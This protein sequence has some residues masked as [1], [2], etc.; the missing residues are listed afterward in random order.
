MSGEIDAPCVRLELI[1]RPEAAR[2]VRSMSSAAGDALG[3]DPELQGDV[4]TAVAE[5]CNNVILHAY[6][7]TPGPLAVT[8]EAR[9]D[10]LEV[11]I[12]DH[13]YGMR[14]AIPELDRLKVGLALMSA[15]AD[16]A[17]FISPPEGGTEVRLAFANRS[18]LRPL[19]APDRVPV[20]HED[21]PDDPADP[22]PP[23]LTGPFVTVPGDVVLT[24]SPV[25]LLGPILGRVGR[26]LAPSAGFSL[27][28]CYDVY[29]LTDALAAH[30]AR[31]AR[32]EAISVALGTREQRLEFALAPLRVGTGG[33][34]EAAASGAPV[35][36][37]SLLTEEIAISAVDNYETLHVSMRDRRRG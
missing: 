34:L 4:N 21:D 8:L 30:A 17:E 18:E 31:A 29:L 33:C 23:A 26:T 25:S 32:A 10:A 20:A 5:A 13:G 19:K 35:D 24:V 3:F 7:D 2:L 9:A 15:L 11:S 6:G 36:A 22:T 14:Q 1:S 16:R 12:R 28:R 37:L 27:E